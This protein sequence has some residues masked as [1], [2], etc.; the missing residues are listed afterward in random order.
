MKEHKKVPIDLDI[1]SDI[2]F[3]V[4]IKQI[5][6]EKEWDKQITDHFN[7]SVK[8]SI[9]FKTREEECIIITFVNIM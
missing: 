4:S 2:E 3:V 9:M 8:K 6:N 1:E 7:N 5:K